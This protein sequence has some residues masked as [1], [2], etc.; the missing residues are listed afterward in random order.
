VSLYEGL[1]PFMDAQ[2]DDGLGDSITYKINGVP[3]ERAPGDPTIPGFISDFADDGG[4]YESVQPLAHRW[5]LKVRKDLL[6]HRPSMKDI[7]ENPKLDGPYR[8]GPDNSIDGGAYW[9]VDLQ[10][11]PA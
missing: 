11:A 5:R 8:P 3:L 4:L 10:R 9:I 6:P 2:V 1:K 7:V